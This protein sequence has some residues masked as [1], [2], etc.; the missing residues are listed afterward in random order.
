MEIGKT[1]YRYMQKYEILNF[2]LEEHAVYPTI[3]AFSIYLPARL[4][5]WFIYTVR[6]PFLDS[7]ACMLEFM[8][9]PTW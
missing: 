7:L 8:H 5:M 6:Y 3:I 9:N 1:K 2:V 4:E